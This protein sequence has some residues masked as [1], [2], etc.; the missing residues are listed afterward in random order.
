MPKAVILARVSTK[1]QEEEGLSLKDIQLPALRSYAKEHDFSVSEKDEFVFQESADI[2]IRKRF[3]EMIAYVKR[4]EDISAIIT[5]RVDRITRNFRDAV[6]LD[7]L[8]NES[9]K[10]IHFVDDHLVINKKSSGRDIMVWDMKVFV[11]KQTINRL[12]DDELTSRNKKLT[13]GELPGHAPFGYKNITLE[14]KKKWI[15]PDEFLSLVVK[16]IFQWYASENCSLLEIVDKV[17]KEFHLKKSKSVIHYILN[18]RFYIGF[19]TNEGKEYRH[20]YDLVIDQNLFDKAQEIMNKRSGDKK[21]FK[22]AGKEFA[23]RGLFRCHECGCVITPDPKKRKLSTGEYAYHPYYHCTNYFKVHEKVKNVD[24]SVIDR[25]LMAIF[26]GLKIPDDQL[27]AITT[28]LKES[29]QDK[30]LFFD[31]EVK[32]LDDQLKRHKNRIRVAYEDRLDGCITKD[33]YEEIRQKAE[34][35][36]DTIRQKNESFDQAEREYYLTTS[37]LVELGTRSAEIFARSKPMEKRALFNFVLS[38]ATIDGEKVRYE[39]KFPFSAVLEYAPSSAWL[40]LA[41]YVRKF[42]TKSQLIVS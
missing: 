7:E 32:H 9:D 25:Q 31:Q 21:R 37:Y 24:E 1:R 29:H 4:C 8:R 17:K 23:Y 27:Q 26:D 10:E 5:Y 36:I 38:N 13:N 35:D 6:S 40:A 14:N 33:Q 30:N 2:K 12:K 18:N 22:Y 34:S 16:R 28:T 41:K 11:A 39:V 19:M 3:D 42:L 15:V 20:Q